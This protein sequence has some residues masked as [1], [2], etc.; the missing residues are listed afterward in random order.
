MTEIEIEKERS[1]YTATKTNKQGMFSPGDGW[2][3]QESS[4]VNR[5]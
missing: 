2:P 5:Q 3:L 1:G 4:I